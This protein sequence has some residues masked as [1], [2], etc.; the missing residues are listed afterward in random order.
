MPQMSTGDTLILAGNYASFAEDVV[1]YQADHGDDPDVDQT[2]LA[3]LVSALTQHSRTLANDAAATAFNDCADAVQQLQQQTA[4][5]VVE[6]ASLTQLAKQ[7]TRVASI[8]AAVVNIGTGLALHNPDATL[9]A[10]ASLATALG[11]K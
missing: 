3:V 5:A 4:S 8:A 6:L 2:Q 10:V 9:K 11:K 1:D 7:Y